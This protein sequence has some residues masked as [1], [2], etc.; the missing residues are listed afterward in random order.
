MT[1]LDY[2]LNAFKPDVQLTDVRG[3]NVLHW[4]VR[5]G[6]EEKISYLMDIGVNINAPALDNR[7][8]CDV[9]SKNPSLR[10]DDGILKTMKEKQDI[11][12]VYLLLKLLLCI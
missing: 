9:P 7:T 3:A 12:K 8:P 2:C 11:I 1:V 4:A 5:E 6:N 10:P